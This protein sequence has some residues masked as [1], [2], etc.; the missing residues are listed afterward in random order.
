[1]RTKMQFGMKTWFWIVAVV[2]AFFL[3]HRWDA[4]IE[5]LRRPAID[6]TA[7][8]AQQDEMLLLPSPYYLS[9][10]VQY[11]PPGPEMQLMQ[12]QLKA[13]SQPS[14]QDGR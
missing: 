11:Y 10:D 3:G 2:A 5:A 14:P 12:Q 6:S 7:G 1:M 9:D 8:S 4:M 13:T